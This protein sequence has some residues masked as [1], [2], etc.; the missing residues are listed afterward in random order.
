MAL[1]AFILI[2]SM[3]ALGS[4]FARLKVLPDNAAEVLNRVVIYL[5]LPAAVL[6]YIPRLH[7]EWRLLGLMLT[8]W[9]VGGVVWALLTCLK[10][11][12]HFRTEEYAVLLLCVAL[13][14][15]GF[16][17][18]PMIH[19]LLGETA[20]AYAV[21]YDQFGTFLML[22]TGGLY[23]CAQYG[24]NAKPT[25]GLILRRILRFPPAL[26]LLAGL[27]V[28]AG[29]AAL[30]NL[31][32]SAAPVWFLHGL[33]SLSNA[34][35]PLVMLA[36]GLSLRFQLPRSEIRALSVGLTLK[37]L[38]LPALVWGVSRLAGLE[39]DIL[40]VNV[41]ETAMPSMVTA[42]VLAMAHNLAPRLAAAMVGYGILIA[43]GTLP[44]W[45]WLLH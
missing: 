27:L 5:C 14:N 16:I 35:L 43:L 12:F 8:P 36:V 33:Q 26:A 20:L 37:L 9:L 13:G 18:Y 41:L 42:A 21:I 39:G 44:L 34:M 11:I 17:G 32:P 40:R 38:V 24:G 23:V 3:L 45:V 6:L 2:F 30:P 4:L 29:H 22:S 7:P 25:P 19:A 15:T 28:M 31:M 1:D 10:K